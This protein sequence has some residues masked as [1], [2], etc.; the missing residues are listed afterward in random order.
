MSDERV[1]QRRDSES[2]P[3]YEAFRTYM[4]LRST[5]KVA[6]ELG[7]SVTLITRWCGEHDWV[8]RITAYDRYIATAD[9][10]GMVH[11]L[12]ESRDKNLALMD[13]L[14]THLSDRLDD[15]IQR[16]EDPTVRW[17]NALAAMAKVE[18]NFLMLKD[19]VKSAEKLDSVMELIKKIEE[20]TLKVPQA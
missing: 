19:D 7:K 5:T 18:Q 1:W 20:N 9:T 15:F 13:K 3:A 16:R 6:A 8:E 17:T 14:R 10:D 4:K 12:A 2:N 11:A